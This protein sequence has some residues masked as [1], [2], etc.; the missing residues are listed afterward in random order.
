[1]SFRYSKRSLDNLSRV[2][3]DMRKVSDRALAKSK[4]DFTV[5]EGVR[6]R[7]R[8][9][10]LVRTGASKTMNSRHLAHPKD[11]LSRAIDVWPIDP[12][13]GKLA[14]SGTRADDR[15]LWELYHQLAPAFKDAAEELGI[16]IVWG[17][18]WKSFPD[19][20]HFELDRKVYP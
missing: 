20:P 17:G 15:R 1:M 19:G 3:G 8:Q 2:H 9:Q 18:D 6:T 10:M 7:E 11:G 13:T 5:I 14:K 12:L 4:I 16:P